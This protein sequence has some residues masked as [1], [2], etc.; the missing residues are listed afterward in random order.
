MVQLPMLLAWRMPFT[1]ATSGRETKQATLDYFPFDN[2]YSRSNWD[3]LVQ[4]AT[5]IK[6]AIYSSAHFK[7]HPPAPQ[8]G[9]A[10]I[11]KTEDDACG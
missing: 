4:A 5:L 11:L 8:Q 2:C 10:W 1:L 6:H 3:L 9:R 7:E